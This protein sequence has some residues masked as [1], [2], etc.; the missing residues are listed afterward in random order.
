[1]ILTVHGRRSFGAVLILLAAATSSC[2]ADSKP[3]KAS[4]PDEPGAGTSNM[5]E[6]WIDPVD[7]ERRDLVLGT[8]GAALRPDAETVFRFRK[9]DTTGH[10]GG[11]EVEDPQG[12]KWDVKIGDESRPEVVASRLLWAIGYHQPV[13]YFVPRW[14]MSGGPAGSE[15]PPPGRF[16]LESDHEKEGEWSWDDSPFVGTRPHRGLVVTEIILN[17]WDF[18]ANNNRIYRPKHAGS[19]PARWFVIQDLGAT[20]GKTKWPNGTIDDLE[21]FL[22]LGFIKKVGDDGVVEFDYHGR[23]RSMVRDITAADVVWTCRLLSRLSEEQLLDAFRTAGYPR[24]KAGAYV[25]KIREKIREGL[26]LETR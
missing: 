17:G 23:H 21:G 20:L 26:A 18:T 25:R 14:R 8:G 5:A 16:R 24:E 19:G 2:G 3:S 9:E 22:T 13:T 15:K 6:L 11:Y 12:R 1:M 7:L 4:K 10:T